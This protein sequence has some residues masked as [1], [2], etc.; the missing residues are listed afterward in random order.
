MPAAGVAAE[1]TREE[2][3]LLHSGAGY[4]DSL[5]LPIERKKGKYE[6]TDKAIIIIKDMEN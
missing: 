2:F 4:F 3:T 1:V 5:L 6:L